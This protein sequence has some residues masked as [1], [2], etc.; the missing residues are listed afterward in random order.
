MDKDDQV[1]TTEGSF[2]RHLTF[3][4]WHSHSSVWDRAGDFF[5][6]NNL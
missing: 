2:I 6:V 1:V 5:L 4:L 3:A